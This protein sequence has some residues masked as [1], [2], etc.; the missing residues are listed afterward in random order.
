MPWTKLSSDN[1]QF[2]QEHLPLIK[3][4]VLER[5][6]LYLTIPLDEIL[7]MGPQQLVEAGIAD[8]LRQ[9][10]KGEPHSTRKV[11]AQRHRLISAVSLIDQIIERLLCT[12]QNKLEIANW[13]DCPSAPG[14]G[15][16]DDAQLKQLYEQIMDI[17]GGSLAEADVTGWDWSVQKWELMAEA[18]LR[19]KLGSFTATARKCIRVRY[20]CLCESVYAMPDGSL[21]ELIHG[22]VQVSGC[23][24]TSSTNSRLRV[25]VAYLVGAEWAKAMGDDCVEDPVEEA[26]EKYA[27]LGHS[28]KMYQRRKDQFEFCSMIFSEEGAWPVDGTKTLF[29][30]LEQKL[31][32]PEL[33][34]QFRQEMR[35]HPRREEFLA[36]AERVRR[37]GKVTSE[38]LHA[39][40]VQTTT[41]KTA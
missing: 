2:V 33:L 10:V 25:L 32:T 4:A 18:E 3:R 15:L 36:S 9:F 19:I 11:K 26:E 17:S 7:A 13:M 37:A 31:I 6:K 12:N 21:V 20:H 8:P 27:E 29:N 5:L 16:S 28:L 40:P 23:F 24:N 14:L 38:T 22:G 34:Y 39:E 35:N 41:E 1:E 30:L